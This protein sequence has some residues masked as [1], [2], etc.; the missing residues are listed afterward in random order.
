MKRESSRVKP[1]SR[2]S[3]VLVPLTLFLI[4]PA[5]APQAAN[6][7]VDANSPNARDT[8]PGTEAQHVYNNRID[9]TGSVGLYLYGEARGREISYNYITN[10]G[11]ALSDT[12]GL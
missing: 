1:H 9:R 12:G 10:S 6:Y 3:L 11:L 7:Y 8:N 2:A 4:V 5:S